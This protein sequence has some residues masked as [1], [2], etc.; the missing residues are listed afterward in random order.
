L[1]WGFGPTAVDQENPNLFWGLVAS[2]YVGNVMLLI[3]NLP[4]VPLSRRSSG[5]LLRAL[6]D[7]LW[8]LHRRR[9]Q[10]QPESLRC[11][12]VGNFGLLGYAMRK[13][14]FPPL[15]WPGMVL[16]ERP[17]YPAPVIDDVPGELSILLAS[18]L[19]AGMLLLAG[20]LS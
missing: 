11:L 12:D 4:L 20:I 5:A 8:H 3:L 16:G 6:S 10:R 14:D 7:H 13:L 9:L 1:L 15:L 18:P 17:S 2:M 19:A